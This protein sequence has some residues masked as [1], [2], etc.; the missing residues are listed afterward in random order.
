MKYFVRVYLNMSETDLTPE[1]IEKCGVLF[2]MCQTSDEKTI[3]VWDAHKP[4]QGLYLFKIRH[5][6]IFYIFSSW[7][8][9]KLKITFIQ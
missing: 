8:L 5:V 2:R 6:F 4:L 3:S 1:E 7:I 9:S